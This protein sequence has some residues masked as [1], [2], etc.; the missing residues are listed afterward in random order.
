MLAEEEGSKKTVAKICYLL[1]NTYS[2]M[3]DYPAA[4]ETHLRY[5][6]IVQQLEDKVGEGRAYWCLSNAYLAIANHKKALH[7][8]NLHLQISTDL[9]DVDGIQVAQTN[10]QTL[11]IDRSLIDKVVFI[12]F[13]VTI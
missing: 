2:L 7:Y 3:H 10:I 5:L 12:S 11:D 9:G 1:A 13:I 8:A 6:K 4:I